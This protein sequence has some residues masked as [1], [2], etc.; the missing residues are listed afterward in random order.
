MYYKFPIIHTIDDV[1]P[2][3]ENRD[4]FIVAERDGYDVINYNVA[5]TDTFDIDTS[6]MIDNHGNMIPKGVMR[7]ECRG[8]IFDKSG[9]I[10][11][12]PFHKFFNISERE[13]TQ[14]NNI[15]LSSDHF[16]MEKMDGSMIRPFDYG[17]GLAIGTK[18]GITDIAVAAHAIVSPALESWME[19]QI[20]NNVT[21]LF[22]FVSPDNRIVVK[23]K[24]PNLV[25]LAIRDNFTGEYL[26]INEHQANTFIN[27]VPMYGSIN[28]NLDDYIARQRVKE[29]RE[30]DIISDGNMRY[31]IKNDWYVQIHKTKDRI[32][33]KRN[34]LK[35]IL[36][37][38][39]DDLLPHLDKEDLQHVRDYEADFH[40][41]FDVCVK[42]WDANANAVIAQSQGDRKR[43][44][45]EILPNSDIPKWQWMYVYKVADGHKMRDLVMKYIVDSL[46]TNVKYN[47][48]AEVV[49]IMKDNE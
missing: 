33:F 38:Q 5:F 6:D 21:P 14:I 41:K 44:A 27:V 7:R 18:M 11:S 24:E 36:D 22:E 42:E 23:Y 15:S 3:I 39:L 20:A 49:G 34:I 32:Q 1:L 25:L 12:R 40:A 8:L 47:A 31:K 2:A 43:L 48:M 13:E 46:N 30:G 28:S 10:V 37:N 4:E 35:L 9:K 45:T 26:D 19:S 16:V 17:E 29:N